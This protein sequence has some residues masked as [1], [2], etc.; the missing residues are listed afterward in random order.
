ME[1]TLYQPIPTCEIPMPIVEGSKERSDEGP[2]LP[3]ILL[4]TAGQATASRRVLTL[5][6]AFLAISLFEVFLLQRIPP[7]DPVVVYGDLPQRTLM[8]HAR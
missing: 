5:A 1:E 2:A 8:E 3:R 6:A 4:Q 7:A